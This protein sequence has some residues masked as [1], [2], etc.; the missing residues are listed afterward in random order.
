MECR[1]VRFRSWNLK[2]WRRSGIRI[3]IREIN[4]S[5]GNPWHVD[6]WITIIINLFSEVDLLNLLYNLFILWWGISSFLLAFWFFI[7]PLFDR[8]VAA[9]WRGWG[10]LLESD[11]LATKD[12]HDAASATR[13]AVRRTARRMR[14]FGWMAH[15]RGWSTETIG[16][17]ESGVETV[18]TSEEGWSV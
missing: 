9:R 13:D 18:V 16:L 11:N 7:W 14:R 10:G 5:R 15:W 17:P 12:E 2:D 4:I 3:V 1:L 8:S 6:M